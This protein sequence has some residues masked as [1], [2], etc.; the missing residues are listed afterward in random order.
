MRCLIITAL[1]LCFRI[2]HAEGQSKS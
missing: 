1:K 2:W